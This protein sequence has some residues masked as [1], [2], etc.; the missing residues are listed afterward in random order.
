MHITKKAILS[1]IAC[2]LI[3]TS[4]YFYYQRLYAKKL[5]N[6]PIL[7]TPYAASNIT[8]YSWIWEYTTLIDGSKRDAL[9]EKFVLTLNKETKIVSSTTD[10][11]GISATF[12]KNNEVLSF[13]P[14]M[15]TQMFCE[16]SQEE[17]YAKEL[18]LTTS[19]VIVN[20]ELHINLNIDFG[21]MVFRKGEKISTSTTTNQ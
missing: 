9:S 4:A 7:V 17:A 13:A 18:A 20:D 3:I 19:Y 11:N 5:A 12:I 8:G 10:C 6:A 16:N 15:G 14:F 21:T 1:I 2:L